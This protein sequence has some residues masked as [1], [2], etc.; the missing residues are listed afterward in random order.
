VKKFTYGNTP[1]MVDQLIEGMNKD[2]K[3]IS[4]REQK[5]NTS[6]EEQ[7][8]QIQVYNSQKTKVVDE[9]KRLATSNQ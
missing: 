3:R 2:L 5:L 8:S 6:N 4:K 7:I 9:L 1:I